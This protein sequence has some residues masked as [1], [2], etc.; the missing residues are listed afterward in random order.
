MYDKSYVMIV[1]IIGGGGAG[2]G[3]DGAAAAAGDS[4]GKRSEN[5][6]S[7]ILTKGL[8]PV[9]G[10]ISASFLFH[11]VFNSSSLEEIQNNSISL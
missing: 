10:F 1:F 2:A 11:S 8:L 4:S 9:M 7:K 6:S 5:G 3:A